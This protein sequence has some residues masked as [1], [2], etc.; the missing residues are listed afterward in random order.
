[1]GQQ[2]PASCQRVSLRVDVA[3]AATLFVPAEEDVM[4]CLVINLSATGAGIVCAEPPPKHTYVRLRLEGLG[5]L[6]GV[7]AWYSE[8]Q[9]GIEFL[10]HLEGSADILSRLA[11]WIHADTPARSDATM[12]SADTLSDSDGHI[13]PCVIANYGCRELQLRTPARPAKGTIVRLGKARGRVLRHL[14]DGILVQHLIASLDG[15]Q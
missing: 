2:L 15:G 13:H 1:M 12:G 6:E 8:G 11:R 7:S 5:E 3:L 4:D 9:L 14:P 10:D